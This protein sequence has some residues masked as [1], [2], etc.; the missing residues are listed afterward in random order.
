MKKATNNK[1][2]F[3]DFFKNL[4][5]RVISTWNYLWSDRQS[6]QSLHWLHLLEALQKVDLLCPF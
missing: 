6:D 2:S 5:M 4:A 3:K 1:H